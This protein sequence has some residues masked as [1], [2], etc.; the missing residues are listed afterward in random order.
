MNDHQHLRERGRACVLVSSV[1]TLR[2]GVRALLAALIR[3]HA[4]SLGRDR[5]NERVR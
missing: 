3:V 5:V 4:I 1:R 2:L